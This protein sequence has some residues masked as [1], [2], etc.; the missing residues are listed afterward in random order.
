M[1]AT[2]A[3]RAGVVALLDAERTAAGIVERAG[4]EV[5]GSESWS[6]GS[7]EVTAQRIALVVGAEDFVTLQRDPSGE[8]VIRAAFA[9]AIRTPE[10]ELAELFVV[11]R[12]PGIHQGWHRAYRDAPAMNAERPSEAAMLA[13]AI[14]LL[15]AEGDVDVDVLR[16]AV[17]EI[18]QVSRHVVRCVLRMRA[19]D[20]AVLNRDPV[21]TSRILKAVRAAATR[22]DQSIA[23]V[24]LAILLTS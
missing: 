12:L 4:V 10:T 2:A 11:L 5:V 19:E 16:G 6:M 8:S 1:S 21:R 22:A 18:A 24:E 7:R 9:A 20:L 3:L 17:L 14:A 13:G 23:S 15:E